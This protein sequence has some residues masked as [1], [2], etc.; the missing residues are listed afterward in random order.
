MKR[1]TKII[2]LTGGLASGKTTVARLFSKRGFPVIDAD[3][4]AHF[5]LLQTSPTYKKIVRSFGPGILN[6]NKKINSK[7]LA[8]IIFENNKARCKLEKIVHPFVL[9]MIKDEILRLKNKKIIILDAPLLFESGIYKKMD[10]NITVWCTR[11]MQIK[12]AIKKWRCTKKEI[13]A[14]INAQ[15]PLS[16]KCN[17]SEFIINNNGPKSG[18]LKAVKILVKF[19]K[20]V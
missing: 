1:K 14:R 8:K 12:R 4:I 9:K 19:L 7:A 10:A 13:V 2:G 11:N 18:L 15:M 16:K 17:L 3:E 5:A 6:K 20:V